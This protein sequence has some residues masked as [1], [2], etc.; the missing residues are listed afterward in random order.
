[1][2]K[3]LQFCA[4]S[5]I[6]QLKR[7][8]GAVSD[9]FRAAFFSQ[10][11]IFPYA[12]EE[13]V[14]M[15]FSNVF[16]CATR[17]RSTFEH[18]VP[19][20]MFRRSFRLADAPES[21]Q[22]RIT[23]L[24]FYDLFVN[25]QKLTRCPLA[26]YISCP[27]DLVYYDDYDLAPHLHAGENVIGV[28]LGN[29][30]MNPLTRTWAF[31]QIPAAS[32]PK[33]ALAFEAVCGGET[34]A[35]DASSFRCTE[36]A[37][38]FDNLRAG[39]F[40]DARCAQPG[41]NAPGFDDSDWRAPLPADPPRG[42]PRVNDA[43]PLRVAAERKPVLVR[44]AARVADEQPRNNPAAYVDF[45]TPELPDPLEGGWL[46]DFGFNDAGTFRLKIHGK[47][48]Q[49]VSII[50][51]E[52][53]TPDGRFDQRNIACFF[54]DGYCQRDIYYCSG[55]GEEVWEPQFVYHGFRYLYVSGITAEQATPDLLTALFFH[56]DQPE[57][58]AFSC[59]DDRANR[60]WQNALRSDHAN[61]MWFPTDC[62]QREKHGWTG[63]ASMSAEHMILEFD[64]VRS[65]RE[66]LNNIR[67]VQRD[68]GAIPGIVPT[69]GWGFA[70]GNGPAWDSVMFNLP[71]MAWKYRG[72][73][74]LITDNAEMMLRYLEYVSR[75][76]DDVGLVHIGLG[77]WLPVV[78]S[79]RT[80]PRTPLEFTDSVMVYDMCVKGEKMFAAVGLPHHAAFARAL[81]AELRTA[82]R[83][84]LIDPNTLLVAGDSQSGQAMAIYYGLL[85]P[86]ERRP[87]FDQ[88]MR[89]IERDG[90]AFSVGFLGLRVIFH[91]LSMFGESALA[92]E[93]IT[94]SEYPSYG[95]YLDRGFTTLPEAFDPD[96]YKTGSWNHHFFGDINHWFMRQIVGLNVNPND[97]NC[98]AVHI[99]PHFIARL[100]HAECRYRLPAG[101]ISVRWART[102]S[103]LTLTVHAAEGITGRISLDPG[104]SF[105]EQRGTAVLRPDQTL[106][107]TVG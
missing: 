36:S 82:I 84:E 75:R 74:A 62:P 97:D 59:S 40:Y 9:V 37:V 25:G 57:L 102:P 96:I 12:K 70:W 20:P 79:D 2:K 60:L 38:R 14:K 91:V 31:D 7:G 43:S 44:P 17:E 88:L 89:M 58:G 66:W 85:E 28:M 69:W 51:G 35:F 10:F 77:D 33:L 94:R 47:P 56:A 65:W 63:D 81:G 53:L 29:G 55:S 90:H 103:G 95:Y 45:V 92:Y 86:A 71:Y 83:R 8:A 27:D 104:F 23:G 34:V 4:R 32:A 101:E 87:A 76:R 16:V 54:P 106:E 67:R 61:F 99:H 80:P 3:N 50:A 68:D 78:F 48:G 26:P 30:M 100:S 105:A 42:L 18:H 46:Y 93:L 19:S 64:A 41:W 13:F 1:M 107:I 21:A 73:T 49:R 5:V 39:V 72:E 6:I 11:L 22:L 98:N 52:M 15:D 24:G